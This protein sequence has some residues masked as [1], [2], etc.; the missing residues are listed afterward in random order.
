[1]LKVVDAIK[2]KLDSKKIKKFTYFPTLVKLTKNKKKLK[3]LGKY[4]KKN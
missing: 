4:L 3:K 1:M 2:K